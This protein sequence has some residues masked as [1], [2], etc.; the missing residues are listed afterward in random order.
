[1]VYYKIT[2]DEGIHALEQI[3]HRQMLLPLALLVEDQTELGVSSAALLLATP[4][5]N[6]TFTDCSVQIR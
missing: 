3:G 6:T 1:M 4:S 2:H 5:W